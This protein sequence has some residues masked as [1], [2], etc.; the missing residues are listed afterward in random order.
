[1]SARSSR[2]LAAV[3]AIVMAVFGVVLVL[4]HHPFGWVIVGCAILYGVITQV[5]YSVRLR[6]EG[7][8]T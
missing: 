6:R 7:G 4:T 1:M 8:S 5:A 2:R 3:A